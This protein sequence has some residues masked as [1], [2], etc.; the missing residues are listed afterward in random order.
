MDSNGRHLIIRTDLL[1]SVLTLIFIY[2][3]YV[4]SQ[5]SSDPCERPIT[6]EENGTRT[7]NVENCSSYFE[8]SHIDGGVIPIS[9]WWVLRR[10]AQNERYDHLRQT[11]VNVS[12]H[13]QPC[14]NNCSGK[15]FNFAIVIMININ[16]I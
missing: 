9:L 16:F 11:C 7:A 2:L 3:S 13:T 12:D 1:I 15:C 8:C 4:G 10:C 14:F 5:Q 6:C